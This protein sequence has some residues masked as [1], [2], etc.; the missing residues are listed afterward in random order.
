MKWTNEYRIVD[1]MGRFYPQRKAIGFRGREVWKYERALY[2]G[3]HESF[4]MDVICDT[5]M[6]AEK[7]LGMKMAERR[8]EEY[9]RERGPIVVSMVSIT[10]EKREATK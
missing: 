10:S 5:R 4:W 9:L 7:W 3:S 6:D 2:A 1:D 8:H